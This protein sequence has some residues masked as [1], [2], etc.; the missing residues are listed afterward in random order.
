M[1]IKYHFERRQ[2]K[3]DSG[4]LWLKLDKWFQA[5]MVVIVWLLAFQLHVPVQSVP[6]TTNVVSLNPAQAMCA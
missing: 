3:D 2:P 6:I 1:V 4:K 5:V